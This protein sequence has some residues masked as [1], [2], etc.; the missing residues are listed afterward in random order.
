MIGTGVF[1]TTG[2]L[3]SDLGSALPV[4]LVWLLGG[5]V[6]ICGALAYGE[7]TA[8]L[9]EN[10]GE[11]ALLSR[12]YHPAVGFTSGWLS[13]VVGF[14]APMAA[15]AVAFGEYVEPL[16]PSVDP[17][18]WAVGLIVALSVLHAVHVRVGERVQDAITWLDLGLVVLLAGAGLALGRVERVADAGGPSLGALARSGDL[19]VGLVWVSFSYSGWNAAAYVAGEVQ[20][21]GRTLPRALFGG[22]A[23]VVLAYLALNAAL[24]ASAP[25]AVLAGEVD[26][27]QVAA[28]H[29]LGA[30]V[31]PFVSAVVA[32]GLATTV[33]ALMVTGPRTYERMGADHPRLSVLTASRRRRGPVRAIGLQTGVAVALAA[34]ATFDALLTYIGFTLALSSALTLLGVFVLRRREPALA[35]PYRTWGHPWTTGLA[36]ALSVWMAG[37]TL[38]RR[39]IAALVGLG[40]VAAGLGLYALVSRRR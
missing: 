18:V 13:L 10:G 11:Y 1:T 20:N 40:T 36:I 9:P 23:A 17:R 27:A 15:S 32:L 21:P 39:P 24:L 28:R 8:A 38:A 7:L 4:M 35:R 37:H 29:L 12:I 2:L 3:S 19:A 33:G 30:A 5:V 22:T 16:V 31:A 6:A 26:V 34:T 25:P 14:S